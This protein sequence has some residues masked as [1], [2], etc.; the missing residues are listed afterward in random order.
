MSTSRAA[1]PLL[2]TNGIFP[3]PG[4]GSMLPRPPIPG[5]KV[6]FVGNAAGGPYGNG[7]TIEKPL[8]TLGGSGG[9][10]ALLKN[11]SNKGDKIYI[12]P[13]HTE[14]VSSAD[15]FSHTGTAAG[16]AI[17]GL[18]YGNQR[19]IFNWTASDSTW[20]VDTAGVE[21]ANCVLNLCGASAATTLTVVTPMTVSGNDCRIIGC[22]INWGL[23][24]NTGC[25]STLGAIAVTGDRFDFFSNRA[26]NLDTAGTLAVSFLSVNGCTGF[27]AIGNQITG[28]TTAT[29]VGA[30]HFL[31]T[32]SD[33]IL[34]AYNAIENLK[35]SSTKALSSAIAGVTGTV[36]RNYFRVQSGIVAETV[37]VTAFLCSFFENYTADTDTLSGALD[38]AGGAS[39]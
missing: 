12:L 34:I 20:L 19:P 18:G 28:G 30:I 31:T 25:G 3:L 24:T 10:L 36:M 14:S 39:S 15:Y 13:G 9:A 38:V 4:V 22:D 16:F 21:I 8:A 23:D 2:V 27:R 37:A 35:A 17:E 11:R 7:E 6:L 26:I 33:N 32:L 5:G 1:G 29:T